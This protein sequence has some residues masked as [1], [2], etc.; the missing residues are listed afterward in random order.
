MTEYVTISALVLLLILLSLPTLIDLGVFL[1]ET[2]QAL[3]ETDKD[4]GRFQAP[5][6]QIGPIRK[7]H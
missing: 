3:P 2:R 1:L 6:W 4:R 7:L 5:T